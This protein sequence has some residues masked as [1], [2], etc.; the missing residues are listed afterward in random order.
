MINSFHGNYNEFYNKT[1]IDVFNCS[2]EQSDYY[3]LLLNNIERVKECLL[4]KKNIIEL[5]SVLI[6]TIINTFQ[7]GFLLRI[8]I[9][10]IFDIVH[11]SNMSK[12]CKS[13]EEAKETV[14]FYNHK[15]E[16][17]NNHYQEFCERF[18][19]DSEEAKILYS[20]YDS[21]YYYKSGNYYLVKN[22][23]TGKALKSINYIP[24]L[25]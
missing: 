16:M 23:S 1:K 20:P 4:V 17:Y 14:S 25:F 21:P 15:Y 8:N 13:E 11:N 2:L 10:N 7:L 3:K 24:V 19:K 6:E 12:L 18:G 22:K 9:N 5:Y